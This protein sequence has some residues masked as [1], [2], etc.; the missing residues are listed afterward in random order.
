[1][2]LSCVVAILAVSGMV[3][4]VYAQDDHGLAPSTESIQISSASVV[5]VAGL[6]FIVTR[7]SKH[8]HVKM[9]MYCLVGA[10]AAAF[11][12]AAGHLLVMLWAQ[13]G[14]LLQSHYNVAIYASV[15]LMGMMLICP[16]LL[17]WS[18]AS[19]RLSKE[20]VEH[21]QSERVSGQNGHHGAPIK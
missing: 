3:Q 10:Y 16:L 12:M 14:S 15:V 17:S 20:I 9:H 4:V 6:G 2:L 19:I 8:E 7:L 18:G 1:M 13:N 5:G 21:A 11:A